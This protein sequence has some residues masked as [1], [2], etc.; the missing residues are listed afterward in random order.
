MVI[1]IILIVLAVFCLIISFAGCFVPVIP[2][3]P[4]AL[5]ALFLIKV[6]GIRGEISWTWICI[7]AGLTLIVTLLDY[8]VPS[9]GAKKFGGTAAGAWGAA[10]GLLAGLFFMPIGIILCPFLGAFIAELIAGTSYKKSFKSAFGT[11]A[12]FMFGVGLKLIL[13]I[14]IAVY[15]VF[16]AFK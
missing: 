9:L 16:A 7:F 8:L 4:I 6:T 14:W 12:G 2:G 15:F 3:P 13:C 11:F 10:I 5:A 1:E